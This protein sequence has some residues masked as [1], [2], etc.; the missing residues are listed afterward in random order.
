MVPIRYD[1]LIGSKH[2][3]WNEGEYT[4]KQIEAFYDFESSFILLSGSYRSGKTEILARSAIRHCLVFPNAKVGIFRAFLASLKKSTLLTILELIHPTWLADWSN[5]DLVARFINGSTISFIGAD[6]PDK[7]GSIELSMAC[8]DEASEVSEESVTM[9]QGRLSAPLV[10]PPNFDSLPEHLQEYARKTIEIR[11]TFLACN[12]KSTSHVLYQ[13]FFKDPKPG[14]KAYVSNSIANTNL[15]VNYLVQNLSA[16]VKDNKS[17]DWVKEQ[18]LKIRAGEA[19]PDGLHLLPYLTPIGQRNM[20][21]KWVALEGAIYDLDESRHLLESAPSDWVPTGKHICGVDFGF[22]NPRISVLKEYTRIINN[23]QEKCY[24]VV[25]YWKDTN[26]TGDDL[27]A[28][29]DKYQ[30]IYNWSQTFLPHDQPGIYKKARAKFGASKLRKAKTS[31]FSG[32]STVSSFINRDRLVFLKKPGHELCWDEFTGYE[33]KKDKNG[34]FLDEPVKKN[35]HFPDSV[36]YALYTLH[37]KEF[38][39]IVE[40]PTG[41]EDF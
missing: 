37:Y 32:I 41:Y 20:I 12:P 28:A 22:H 3:R 33:W 25:D 39:A 27:I 17:L 34:D 13:K 29:L 14:H 2:S 19:D 1:H 9:V 35:D 24:A 31:V 26:S 8:I 36:R 23:I 30:E 11:Q 10:L 38:G 18:I 6:T 7:L 40:E 21:G 4:P 16:Y 15:P 5:T